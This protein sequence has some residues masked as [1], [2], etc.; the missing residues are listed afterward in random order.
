[1]KFKTPVWKFDNFPA[2]QIFREINLWEFRVSK[3][4]ISTTLE[5]LNSDFGEFSALFELKI[6]QNHKSEP[7]KNCQIPNW[8]T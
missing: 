3:N 5:A 6:A 7:K 2:I 1:M 8:F 4:A